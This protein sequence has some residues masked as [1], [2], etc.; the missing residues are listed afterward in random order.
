MPSMSFRLTWSDL[1][2]ADDCDRGLLEQRKFGGC[3]VRN[4]FVVCLRLSMLVSVVMC[5]TIAGS[6]ED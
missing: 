4:S 2:S 1:S 3:S 5:I 6:L